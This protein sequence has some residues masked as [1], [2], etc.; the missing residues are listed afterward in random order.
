[1][2]PLGFHA[3]TGGA[4]RGGGIAVPVNGPIQDERVV[5][6]G[7]AAVISESMAMMMRCKTRI[8]P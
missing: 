6:R 2:E 3:R 4:I 5:E 1:M 8:V 7:A